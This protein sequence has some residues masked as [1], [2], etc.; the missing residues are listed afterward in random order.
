VV[1][2]LAGAGAQG[3]RLVGLGVR[4]AVDDFGTGYSSLSY[5]HRLS[6]DTLKVDRSFV[7]NL[8]DDE[9]CVAI[10]RAIVGLGKSLH[11]QLVAEGVET[12]EQRA[13]LRELGCDL[14]QGFLFSRP[15]PA[16]EFD[17][18]IAGGVPPVASAH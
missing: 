13:F 11:L 7:T 9:N 18:L 4:L 1:D 3:Q 10:A 2:A 6:I 5:L 12:P 15:L 14:M 17:R 16:A 8:P